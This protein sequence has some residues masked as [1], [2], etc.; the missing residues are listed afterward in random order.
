MSID[1]SEAIVVILVAFLMGSFYASDSHR[2]VS[3]QTSQTLAGLL[4]YG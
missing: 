2:C 1:S 3:I 4:L